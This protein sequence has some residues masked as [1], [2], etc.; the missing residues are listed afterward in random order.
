MGEPVTRIR[1]TG[2]A[3]RSEGFRRILADVFQA[4]IETL[5]V[6]DSAGLGAAMRAANAVEG[7]P[8]ETLSAMFSIP[9]ETL[10]PNPSCA[11]VYA[12]LLKDFSTFL[13]VSV[14]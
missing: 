1:L 8:F 7:I 3:S 9:G 12:N 4:R 2:G 14:I 5:S 6:T 11:P 13:S 10:E